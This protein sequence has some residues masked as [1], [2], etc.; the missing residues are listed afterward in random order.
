MASL[1]FHHVAISCGDL[2]DHEAFY[3][4]HFGFTRARAIPL[5][6]GK[7]DRLPEERASLPRAVPGGRG[8]SIASSVGAD[9]PHYPGWRHIAFRVDDVDATLAAMGADARLTLGPWV[10]TR[11][12]PAGAP[13]GLRSRRQHRRDQSG[14]RG[15]LAT[16]RIARRRRW[17]ATGDECAGVH[18]WWPRACLR[19][20]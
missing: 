10:L 13:V 17:R 9:G 7:R 4:E 5:G 15:R 19:R 20:G 1:A 16:R 18:D 8:A 6:G 2:E 3:T 14:V 11:S 12:F